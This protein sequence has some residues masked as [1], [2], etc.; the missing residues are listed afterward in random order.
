LLVY[1]LRS[2]IMSKQKIKE[3]EKKEVSVKNENL[4]NF[5]YFIFLVSAIVILITLISNIIVHNSI[6]KFIVPL[7]G[8]VI[9][10]MLLIA[11]TK[12]LKKGE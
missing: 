5:T 6:D 1:N 12:F 9:L 7:L 4:L 10:S 8:F 11:L 3:T 2:D